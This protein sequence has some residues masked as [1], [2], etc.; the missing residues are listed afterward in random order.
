MEQGTLGEFADPGDAVDER[1]TEE[2]AAVAGVE[3][4][5][6]DI[7]DISD[8]RFPDATG[9]VECAVTQVDYTVEGSGDDEH[10]VLHVFGR[11]PNSD[12]KADPVHLRVHGFRPYFY[13]PIADLDLATDADEPLVESD[14]VDSRLEHD[15]LT[16]IE[17]YGDRAAGGKPTADRADDE[18]VVYESIRGESLVKVFW[19]TPRDVGQLRDRFEH[20]EADILFPNRLLIDK[21]ITSG[22]R[23]PERRLEDGSLKIH[24]AEIAPVEVE[25]E[26]RVHT[27]DI[28]VDDR[29]G[30]PEDGEQ[31]IVCLTSHDSYHDEYVVWLYESPEGIP[32][33]EVIEGYD[34]IGDDGVDIEVRAFDD[35]AE[36][37]DNYVTYIEETDPDYL[38]GWNFDDFDAPYLID[39]IDRLAS[40]HDELDSGRL[41][42]VNEVWDSGWG[43]PNIKGR[44]V[45][46]LLY[47]Y[48]RTQFS[49]LDSYR[50]DAVGEEELGVG[51]ERY[52]G[53]I[54]DLWEDDPERLIEYNLRDVELCVELDRKQEIIPFWEEVASF[55]GCKLEDATTPGDA[56][57]MYVLHEIHGEF[58]LPSKGQQES[59]EYEGGA[60]FEPI[61]GVK[62]M[63][64][65][66]DLKSLYPM[67]MVTINASP[68]TKVDP[69]AYDDETYVAPNGTHFRKEPDG[70]IREMVDEL[71]EER[72]EKKS[73]R[74]EN[75]PG[76]DAYE[77]YDRQQAAVK[78]I[79]NCF[80][81]DTDVLTPSGIRNIR[82]LD[83]GDEVY[84]LDPETMKME[85]KPVVETHEYPDYRGEL[86]DIE[87]SKIDFSVTPNHRMLVR[88]NDKNGITEEGWDFVEAGELDDYCNYELPHGWSFDHEDSLPEFVDTTEML[89]EYTDVQYTVADGSGKVAAKYG[90]PNIRRQIPVNDF[91][92][93]LAWY[94]SEGT[95]YEAKTGNYR[96]K[97]AQESPEQQSDIEK[98]IDSIADYW[99][100]NERSVS[101]SSRPIGSLFEGLCG[102]GSEN[103]RIPEFVFRGSKKQKELFL[104]ALIAGDGDR[105]TNSWRYSTKS[106]HLRDD[107]LRLCTHLGLTATYN[108]DS[109]DSDIWRIYC[110]EDGKNSFR[111]HRDGSHRTAEN[112]VYCVTVEDNNTLIAG[113]NGKMHNVSNSLYGV[114]GWDRFRLYDKEMGAAVT[115]TG[116]EVIEFTEQAAAELNKEVTYGDTDSIMLELGG[117]ISK[118]EAIGQSFEIED[119]INDAYDEFAEQLNAHTHRFEIEFEKLYRRFFQA[120]KKKR[121]AGNII[122]KEG[123]E[124]D[125]IDITGF[126]YKRSDIAP[127]TKEVQKQVLEMIVTGADREDIK[128]YVH[129]VIERVQRGDVS[130]SEIGIP[131]G[132]GKKLDNYDTETAQV[133]GAKYANLLL[134]TNF[135]SGSKPKRLYLKKVHPE[136]FRRIEAERDLDPSRDPLYGEFKRDPDVICFEFDDQLPDAFEIDYEKMLEKTLKGPI[137]RILEALDISWDEVKSGQEQTGLG[138]FV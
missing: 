11:T 90:E 55:V 104:E 124:V 70:M 122:W 4:T 132:I 14:V 86:V 50:L 87:T 1:P 115:A 130:P 137:A 17:T 27:L 33:P 52:P 35:E 111:M 25:A 136:F 106:E 98:L 82:D 10:P 47:A 68:E 84:S 89:E 73:L 49:E 78:V 40:R 3:H 108:S 72:E 100:V 43:G 26:S 117:E 129:E 93:L 20:Y 113:R 31:T 9:D 44:V 96:V 110:T 53:D 91:L 32:G 64:S 28:E 74:N 118:E 15:R 83:I 92:E 23:V 37:L 119:H 24:H 12:E 75:D 123:K 81:P 48:Q 38:T 97:I 95:V 128:D 138:N 126:E 133:R 109:T 107:V 6:A 61:S 94:I 45:F 41:S 7:V 56:V 101:F 29:H 16:G 125:D 85:T 112:G 102:R 120:G 5:D 34:P 65:V 63:V 46:D 18:L 19:Q 42:R 116:R 127:I 22:V 36:M 79:M 39:R 99:Y 13:T 62:E 67:C 88:K 76:S 2:A 54:G 51:K 8:R 60:V 57:D 114:L 131:G 105:Q 58:A 59:E 21:D 77:T 69:D 30:F 66:L 121:Y 71:L 134:G 103:K 80:T 135:A